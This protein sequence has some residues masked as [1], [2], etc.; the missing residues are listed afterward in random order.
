[1]R[2]GGICEHAVTQQ[3]PACRICLHRAM[4]AASSRRNASR[5]LDIDSLDHK[6]LHS[7]N[8]PPLDIPSTRC[9]H[10]CINQPF[11][12]SHGMEKQL[13]YKPHTSA[14]Q[15]HSPGLSVDTATVSALIKHAPAL[16]MLFEH[17]SLDTVPVWTLLMCCKRIAEWHGS[18]DF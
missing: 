14:L 4:C 10:S 16:H 9:L 13:L 3:S 6:V 8:K 5:Q 7:F 15:M 12:P 17:E 2:H 11:T 1:M 18:L